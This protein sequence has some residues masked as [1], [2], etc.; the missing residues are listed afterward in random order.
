MEKLFA[1]LVESGAAVQ[2]IRNRQ[3]LK[4]YPS[5]GLVPEEKVAARTTNAATAGIR[6]AIKWA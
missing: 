1:L 4:W 2:F 3:M 5:A 6:T